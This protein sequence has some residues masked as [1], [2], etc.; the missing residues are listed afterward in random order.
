MLK[1]AFITTWNTNVGDD[2]VREGIRSVLDAIWDYRPYLINKHAPEATCRQ[3]LPEDDPAPLGDKCLDADAVVQCGAPVYWNL[4]PHSG[5]KCCTAEWIAPLWYDRIARICG[6]E[7]VLNIAAGACQGYFGT[8]AEILA[9]PSCERFIRDIHRFCRLTTVR[10]T[11][12]EDIHRRLGLQVFRQPCASIFAWRRH[13]VPAKPR[14]EIAVNFMPRGGHYDLDGGVDQDAWAAR[15]RSICDLLAR[16]GEPI[17]PIAHERAELE[18]M[19]SLL[20]N[21]P[22]LFSEDYRDYF[23]V[24]AR[25]RGGVF[26]RVHGALLLAGSGAPAAVIGNDSR[27]RMVDELGLP[28]WH[29][30]E[31]EPAVVVGRLLELVYS[32]QVGARLLEL[33]ARSF[34]TLKAL[35]AEALG[36]AGCQTGIR[37]LG[38]KGVL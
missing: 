33:E 11:L 31:A 32:A 29:V 25:C 18:A 22:I 17:L 4:G 26:N 9:D 19:R 1:I 36:P 30:S 3:P 5:Q 15:F 28:R 37:K 34:E 2:F 10:D 8:A 23:A 14:G 35:F 6:S 20:P 24:Y 12:A 27:S 21:R 16:S 7:P 13:P 38:K